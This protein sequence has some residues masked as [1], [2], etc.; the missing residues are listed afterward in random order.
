MQ[1]QVLLFCPMFV[2]FLC[3]LKTLYSGYMAK[4]KAEHLTAIL[5]FQKQTIRGGCKFIAYNY[6]T[7]AQKFLSPYF[8]ARGRKIKFNYSKELEQHNVLQHHEVDTK[9]KINV[10]VTQ[11]E[12]E[13][14]EIMGTEL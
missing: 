14:K 12:G 3:V 8:V 4:G 11:K 1:D 5:V 6:I 13:E 7:Y 10:E 2:I 9:P